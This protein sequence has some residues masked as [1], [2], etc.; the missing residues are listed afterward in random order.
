MSCVVN[1]TTHLK[2]LI[3]AVVSNSPLYNTTIN[4]VD[5]PI[6]DWNTSS[7]TDMA[8]IF[9]GKSFFDGNISNG[10]PVPSRRW[11]R[12]SM[13]LLILIRAFPIGTQV[14][15]K[16][17]SKCFLKVC[18]QSGHLNMGHEL[19]HQHGASVFWSVCFQPG[20]LRM[21]HKFSHEHGQDV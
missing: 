17:C 13:K 16:T 5:C 6:A 7:V 2:D 3:D 15:W 4:G 9:R 11:N 20:H 21:E 10:T 12:C 19:R 14:P 18:I 8:E 1:N